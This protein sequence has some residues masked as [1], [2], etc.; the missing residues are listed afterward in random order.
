MNV[1]HLTSSSSTKQNKQT[2]KYQTPNIY[3]MVSPR[4][5]IVLTSFGY[6]PSIDKPT[7][8]Y[9]VR[10]LPGQRKPLTLSA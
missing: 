3:K 4:I 10:L 5:L 6:I 8:W 7:G 2:F 9:L 1:H